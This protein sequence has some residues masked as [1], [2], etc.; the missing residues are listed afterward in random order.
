MVALIFWR[1]PCVDGKTA[2][3]GAIGRNPT[4]RNTYPMPVVPQIL[5]SQGS[6]TNQYVRIAVEPNTVA[7]ALFPGTPILD[8]YPLIFEN[9]SIQNLDYGQAF[10]LTVVSA[11]QAATFVNIP[12]YNAAQYPEASLPMQIS[13]YMTGNWYDPSHSG[14]GVQVEVGELQSSDSSR[15]RYITVAWYTFDSSGIPYWL[16]GSGV[17]NAGDRSAAVTLGYSSGGGFAGNSGGSATAKLWGTFN[18]QFTD[19]NTMKFSYQSTTGLPS[20]IPAGS[21]SKT[22][23]RLSSMN[24]LACQ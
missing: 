23:T 24:G 22:W 15:P 9:S 13:G 1:T 11:T 10:A 19:C 18:V 5:I 4:L 8:A 6:S 7:S 20:G 2:F 16:F 21:G 14:E 3:L 17:F 12:A